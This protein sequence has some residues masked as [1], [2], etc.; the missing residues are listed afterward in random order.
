MRSAFIALTILLPLLPARGQ[1]ELHLGQ[2][3]LSDSAE[4]TLLTMLPG[5]HVYS[6]FGHSA[7]LIEDVETGLQKTYNYGT[8]DFN[9]PHFVLRF[10]QGDLNYM[11]D[12]APY[13]HELAKYDFLQRP[14][15][16]QRL[17]LPIET[18]QV[19]YSN[20]ETNLLPENREYR[21][22]FLF[23]NC[24]TRLL[25]QLNQ[26][27][28]ESGHSE[29]DFQLGNDSLSFRDHLQPYLLSTPWL[30]LGINLGL[31]LPADRIASHRE[32]SFLPLELMDLYDLAIADTTE[33]VSEKETVLSVPGYESETQSINIPLVFFRGLFLFGVLLSFST[34]KGQSL[35]A[36]VRAFDVALFLVV[37]LVGLILCFL[38]FG[39]KHDVTG[40]N[41][42]LLWALPSHF[43]TA[44]GLR[45]AQLSRFMTSYLAFTTI[46]GI[47][48]L[49]GW[50]AWP[51]T[52]PPE[53]IPLV[54]LIVVRSVS[55]SLRTFNLAS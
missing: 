11:I 50:A 20:L 26:A 40:P 49:I 4:V 37:G 19:L 33:L 22:D 29:L 7:L 5:D 24:S 30:R 48:V 35:S 13:H 8:F 6:K 32:E 45:R 41:F 23:D 15:I 3:Q 14:I 16:A 28:V 31:G 54:A 44:F 53:L 17:N 18:R 51:Q 34:L 42:N 2:E 27:L 39:T 25:D 52:L 55:R 1:G 21:Y 38:W 46:I 10:L 12:S 36:S 43:F 9:Q 47:V